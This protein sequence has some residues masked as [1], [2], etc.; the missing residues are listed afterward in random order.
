MDLE[1]RMNANKEKLF[2]SI[3]GFSSIS[4]SFGVYSPYLLAKGRQN[5]D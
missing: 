2:V 5:G 4:R 1:P 3:R